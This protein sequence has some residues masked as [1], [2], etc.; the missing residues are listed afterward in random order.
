MKK[1]RLVLLVLISVFMTSGLICKAQSFQ[2]DNILG[3][4]Y[5]EDNKSIVKIY[6]K[7]DKFYG[8]IIWLKNPTYKDKDDKDY[9]KKK[10]DRENPKANLRS[11]PTIGIMV[12]KGFKF[13]G[14][15]QWT[16]GTIYDPENGKTYDCKMWLNSKKN[17]LG[18]RGFIG[19]SLIGRT[20]NW[21]RIVKK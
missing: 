21:K 18:V 6:R 14:E 20:T 11:R 7:G 2:R 15:E 16:G 19:F 10:Y 4:W 17:E 5:T 1:Q 8:K 3:K 12:L 9:G 13:D